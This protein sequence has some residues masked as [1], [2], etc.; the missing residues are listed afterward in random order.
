MAF[1]WDVGG[2]LDINVNDHFAFQLVQG[3]YINTRTDGFSGKPVNNFRL[4]T[5]VV[6][7]LGSK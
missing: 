7:R 5:G 2:G 4:A 3:D 6:F 1:A